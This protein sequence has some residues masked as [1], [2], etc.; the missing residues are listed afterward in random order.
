M[1]VS[2]LRSTSRNCSP[3]FSKDR[4][5]SPMPRGRPE[6]G[7]SVAR[8]TTSTSAT[9]SSPISGLYQARRARWPTSRVIAVRR[10]APPSAALAKRT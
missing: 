4:K 5:R 9:T 3:F 10:N 2:A 8:H 1:P 7:A 6:L